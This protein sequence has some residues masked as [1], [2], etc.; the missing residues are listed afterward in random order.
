MRENLKS[1]DQKLYLA[2][3]AFN[4]ST[5]QSIDLSPFT[6]VYGHNPHAPLDLMPIPYLK[7]AYAKAEDLTA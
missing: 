1:W 7:R 5:N 2:E 4:R 6:I 3:F